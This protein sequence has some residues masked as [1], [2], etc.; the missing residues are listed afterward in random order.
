MSKIKKYIKAELDTEIF[1]WI[2][3]MSM[4]FIYGFELYVYGVKS[5]EYAIIFQMLL[6]GYV[7]AWTQKLLFLK[8]R[9]YKKREYKIRVVLWSVLPMLLT[10]ITG[11]VLH[12]YQKYP[13]VL[14]I[15]FVIIMLIYYIMF[16]IVLEV[17]YQEDTQK[18]NEKLG[19]LKLEHQ[20]RE[21]E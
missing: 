18:L 5:L 13:A 21:V 9:I 19:I 11:I 4:I 17:L 10:G 20:R 2:H 16:W 3:S 1:A 6:L 14:G 15:I 8:D 12:W 7:I